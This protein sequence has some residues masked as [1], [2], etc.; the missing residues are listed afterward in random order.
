MNQP[1][2][3]DKSLNRDQEFD[4]PDTLSETKRCLACFEEGVEEFLNLGKTAL[5]N[6]FIQEN[7]LGVPTPEFPLRLG[8]CA[9]CGMVQLMDLADPPE[10]FSHYL[11][12]SSVSSTLKDHLSELAH[13]LCQ[14]Y[15]LN[16]QHFAVDIGSNDG[17]L[18][19]AF[20]SNEVRILGVDPASNLVSLA[21]EKNIETMNAFFGEESA[22]KI[23]E[24]YG[25]ANIITATNVFQHIPD[26]R[27]MLRGLDILLAENG[28]FVFESHY[29][30]DMV[31]QCAFDTVY[32][33]HVFYFSI[34]PLRRHFHRHGFRIVDVERLPIHHGQIRVT[35][36]RDSSPIQTNERVMQLEAD[37]KAKGYH[38]IKPFLQFAKQANKCRSQLVDLI[39]SLLQ[40]GKRIAAYGAPAKGNTLL[41]SCDLSSNQL[42]YIVDRSPLKQGLF[43]PGTHIPIVPVEKLKTDPTDFLLILAW[44]FVEEITAQLQWYSN[45]GGRFILPVPVPK[46]I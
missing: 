31:E 24:Q 26:Q 17:T 22:R 44:N 5:A 4:S 3:Q 30:Q 10:M 40:Q 46:I 28:V 32:H 33:E 11:Y 35:V 19:A 25:P 41:A 21:S 38:T 16:G 29:L 8:F 27:D 7:K 37:E 13:T 36:V 12:I 1:I 42:I 34:L 14:K 15:S 39:N 20:Q 6:Q 45:S 23:L 9:N 18:L 43:T 2:N